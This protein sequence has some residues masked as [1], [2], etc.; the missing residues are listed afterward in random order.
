M[1]YVYAC[2]GLV[3]AYPCGALCHERMPSA[4]SSA[5]WC[6]I[7]SIVRHQAALSLVAIEHESIMGENRGNC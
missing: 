4:R 3:V 6:H 1:N 2:P 7:S 5:T